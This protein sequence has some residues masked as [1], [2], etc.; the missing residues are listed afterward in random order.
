MDSLYLRKTL[1][2]PLINEHD[3]NTTLRIAVLG[4]SCSTTLDRQDDRPALEQQNPGNRR[5]DNQQ[6][7]ANFPFGDE[8]NRHNGYSRRDPVHNGDLADLP[9]GCGH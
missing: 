3:F 7:R 8:H 1:F 4:S 2:S 9:S 5:P 6:H